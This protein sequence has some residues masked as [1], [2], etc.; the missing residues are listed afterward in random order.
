MIKN[1]QL[2]EELVRNEEPHELEKQSPTGT[3][4]D[5]VVITAI[6]DRQKL[7][8]QRQL[9]LKL[10]AGRVPRRFKYKVICD[11][12]MCKVGSGG[13]TMHVLNQIRAEYGQEALFRMKILLLQAGGYSQRMPMCTVLGK[14]F[15]S[16]PC[17]SDSVNDM[18]D[19]KLANYLPFMVHM[20]PGVFMAC[21][22][23]FETFDFEQ[24]LTVGA[25]FG[26]GS[27]QFVLL[28]HKSPLSIAK[29]H[30]VYV[31]DR[32]INAP[33]LFECKRVLQ[34]PPVEK[35]KQLDIVLDDPK[36][37]PYVFTDSVFY[38]S[39]QI[40][41][42]L[43]EFYEL[44]FNQVVQLKIEIDAYRDFLQ[45]LGNSPLSL[46][47]YLTP[48]RS[49]GSNVITEIFSR[50]YESLKG[51]TSLLLALNDSDFFHL[52]TLAET[53]ELYFGHSIYGEKFRKNVCMN[54]KSSLAVNSTIGRGV[55][56]SESSLVDYCHF[57]DE[58]SLDVGAYCYV[59]NCMVDKSEFDYSSTKRPSLKVPDNVSLHTIAIVDPQSNAT[60]Y[61][62]IF[63]DQRDDLKKMYDNL[64][65]VR[66]LNLN[67]R[68]ELVAKLGECKPTIW[69]LKLFT[70]F[71]TMSESF[72]RSV[73]F[74]NDYLQTEN[75]LE[76]DQN[77]RRYCLF[78]LLNYQNFEKMISYREGN[79]RSVE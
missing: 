39:H 35:M 38:F 65:S 43:L 70:A 1:F 63:I 10:S 47:D 61:V 58:V 34:K 28:A 30:G 4:I 44:Y 24:Q 6:D 23:D 76:F 77:E 42:C 54:I 62:T 15:S 19:L 46:E 16:V 12:D 7:C 69:Q 29:D 72:V 32:T 48:F 27:S 40:S 45:P 9:E 20:H 11:P 8:Y 14:I 67:L 55:T 21:S 73:T 18:L 13:S 2:Y 52:G 78:D 71:D 5:L 50:L 17:E 53:L 36:I 66:F 74:L 33:T 49:S 25:H 57:D 41:Q 22:D 37:G 64:A 31:L 79:N 68:S 59:N 3:L 56:L 51:R 75:S 60:K 26:A